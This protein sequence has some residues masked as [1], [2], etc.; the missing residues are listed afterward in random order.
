M[1]KKNGSN[2]VHFHQTRNLIDFFLFEP[3]CSVLKY[4]FFVKKTRFLLQIDLSRIINCSTFSVAPSIVN[5]NAKNVLK[6]GLLILI[7]SSLQ[8]LLV[9]KYLQVCSMSLPDITYGIKAKSLIN[10]SEPGSGDDFIV[11][12]P[13]KLDGAVE[14]FQVVDNVEVH[15]ALDGNRH[16]CL[17]RR[18]HPR[19]RQRKQVVERGVKHLSPM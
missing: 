5:Q 4:I 3:L 11:R 13:Y 19:R 14:P 10:K 8:A 6:L 12:P 7:I 15:V 16:Q 18:R 2:P 17:E 9:R 1:G